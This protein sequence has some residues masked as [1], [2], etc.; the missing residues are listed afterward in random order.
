[1][2]INVTSCLNPTRHKLAVLSFFGLLAPI[3][4]IPSTVEVLVGGPRILVVSTAAAVMVVL[5]TT[6]LVLVTTTLVLAM[7]I[8]VLV[9]TTLS[10]G[11]LRAMGKMMPRR[12]IILRAVFPWMH[13]GKIF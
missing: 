6:I 4:F 2:K 12:L 11:M 3:Y 5:M 1:M 10:L 7:M 13:S 8:L 9:T